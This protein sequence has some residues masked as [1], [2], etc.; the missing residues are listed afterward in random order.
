M[1]QRVMI[2]AGEAS[3]DLHGSGVVRELKRAN[4]AIEIF[5]VGGDRMKSEGM[6]LV[7]HVNE[8]G[9]MGFVE[10]IKHLPVI[11]SMKRTLEALLRHRRPDVVLLIDYPGF[12]LR[13]AKTAKR[14]G[15]K[16][17][18]YISP[19]V[20][21][22]HR[23]RVKE[24]RGVVDRMLVIFPFEEE[25]YRKEGVA[26]EFVGHPLLEVL[27]SDLDRT[28][29]CRRYSLDAGKKILA[30]LPGSRRQEIEMILPEMLRAARTVAAE[31]GVEIVLALAPTLREDHLRTFY[32]LE[33]IRVIRDAAYDVM[34]NADFAMVTSGTATLE[35]GLFGTPMCVVYKT[36]WV[37]YLL[38]RL[39]IR[40]KNIGLVN[41]VA[42][43]E[44]VPEFIQHRAT[45]SNLA[46][47]ALRYLGDEQL[48]ADTREQLQVVRG[49]LGE[50]GAS[51]RV[52]QRILQM[53]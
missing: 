49:K 27:K 31:A 14:S 21:A 30:L 22:W 9:F 53:G 19:Q 4:P 8:L 24:M 50:K 41:I 25:L 32:S 36:S 42:G 46:R 44:V 23:S 16:V 17:V 3:G 52:A 11:N 45:A 13:F 15:V 18:Y 20:W 35:T 51:G 7:Y 39:L 12:N 10:V 38:G 37:T 28:A 2:I 6:Q 5:G 40:V 43:K 33:G 48:L 34:R 26:V 1:V 29:F 47:E